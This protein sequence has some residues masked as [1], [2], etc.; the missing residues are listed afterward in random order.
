MERQTGIHQKLLA[1]RTSLLMPE[2]RSH[3][4]SNQVICLNKVRCELESL[5]A[6]VACEERQLDRQNEKLRAA[7]FKADEAWLRLN[8]LMEAVP[9]PWVSTDFDGIIKKANESA[10]D[11][12]NVKGQ[13]LHCS[14][15]LRFMNDANVR[16]AREHLRQISETGKAIR[17]ETSL[18]PCSEPEVS[19]DILLV[20]SGDG[21]GVAVHWFI[22]D[23][24]ELERARE[25]VEQLE[26]EAL[27]RDAQNSEIV[28]QERAARTAM[29]RSLAVVGHELRG[30][31]SPLLG[32]VECLRRTP[33]LPEEVVLDI[34][35][36]HDNVQ[37]QA[38]LISDLYDYARTSQGKF[39]LKFEPTDLIGVLQRVQASGL[40]NISNE[41][42]LVIQQDFPE[43]RHLVYSTTFNGTYH[44]WRAFL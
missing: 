25:R 6:D 35:V 34:A 2:R 14:A 32:V 13:L 33:N 15:I 31:L 37:L 38:R 40:R 4:P 11:F 8:E 29:E 9:S 43:E 30:H 24:C 21:E 16:I 5:I 39:E 28:R 3:S 42:H 10:A 17:W 18:T 41:K 7:E 36:I 1:L 20:A 23:A 27:Q 44:A 26:A 12:L 22:R 19:V